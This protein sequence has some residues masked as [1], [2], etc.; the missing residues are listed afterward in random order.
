[1]RYGQQAG[2]ICQRH[3][4]GTLDRLTKWKPDGILFQV[5]EYDQPLLDYVAEAPARRVGLRAL[6]GH[7]SS[8][9]LVLHDF[10]ALGRKV[11]SHFI[12]N[13]YRRL[14]YLGPQSD[15]AANAGNTYW[16]GM[17]EVAEAS[18]VSLEGIFPD[19][20]ATWKM[21]GLS[22]RKR[23]TSRWE[24]FWELGPALVDHL[25]ANPEPVALFSAFMEPAM[26]FVEMVDERQIPIPTRIGMAAHTDDALAGLVTKV[27]LTCVVP[28]YEK[29]GYEA[30]QL[31]DRML[32]GERVEP[33]HRL[34]LDDHQFHL[35]D[36]SRQ[37]VTSDLQVSQMLDHVRRNALDFGYTPESLAH[38]FGCSLRLIQIRFRN[39]LQRG[40]AEVIRE[41]RTQHAV[42]L[43][44]KTD[45]PLQQIVT[46]CGFSGHHQLER[47]VR[48]AHGLNPSSLRKNH[49]QEA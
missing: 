40:V 27:P 48:K 47:A 8:T 49:R 15:E 38:A 16:Q 46:E 13:N 20:L 23:P 37:I 24:R 39:T 19:Q 44:C 6:R 42:E 5:D 28:D 17:V 45:M 30:A 21:L 14:C 9:P 35:R 11:A 26:E 32:R 2:W 41:H 10:A 22:F 3:D 33:G 7:E 29:Q 25:T 12:S 18:R 1:M 36:S 4:A 31:L 43:I 34:F